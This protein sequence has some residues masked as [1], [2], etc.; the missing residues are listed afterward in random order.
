M[1][2]ED[3]LPGVEITPPTENMAI[4]NE[5]LWGFAAFLVEIPKLF[6]L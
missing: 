6:M 2:L 4:I 1:E 3:C 5:K